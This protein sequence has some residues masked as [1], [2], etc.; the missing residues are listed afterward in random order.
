[1]MRFPILLLTALAATAMRAQCILPNSIQVSGDCLFLNVHVTFNLGNATPPYEYAIDV[2]GTQYQGIGTDP[3][4]FT[5]QVP[6][7]GNTT[8]H[9]IGVAVHDAADCSAFPTWSGTISRSNTTLAYSLTLDCT[10]G[11]RTLRW[12]NADQACGSAGAHTARVGNSTGT[13]ASLFTQESPS[14]WRYNTALPAPG[15]PFNIDAGVGAYPGYICG[16]GVQCWGDNASTQLS[17]PY[18]QPGDCGV[19]FNLKAALQGPLATNGTMGEGLRNA[20]LV[21]LTE[22]YSALGYSYTGN[23]SLTAVPSY[24]M[25]TAPWAIVDWVVVELRSAQNPATVV[26]SKPALI[27]KDGRIHDK[28]FDTYLLPDPT[29]LH[30]GEATR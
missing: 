16:T 14:V 19:N 11:L 21:P 28:N 22:P 24:Y 9:S 18:V 4:G 1:M 25:T 10:T 2:E 3:S 7:T 30:D 5:Y 12:T 26:Y 29:V 17:L 15:V 8:V 27:K 20:N 6:W 23:P 13:V